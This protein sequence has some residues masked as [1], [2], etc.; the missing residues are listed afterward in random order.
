MLSRG[1]QLNGTAEST[2]E[3]GGA[4]V[5][6]GWFLESTN[7]NQVPRGCFSR[8]VIPSPRVS[9]DHPRILTSCR[10]DVV[11][12]VARTHALTHARIHARNIT[13]TITCLEDTEGVAPVGRASGA[14]RRV[15]RQFATRSSS[16]RLSSAWHCTRDDPGPRSV[17]GTRMTPL[18]VGAARL[19][20]GRISGSNGWDAMAFTRRRSLNGS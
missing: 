7:I 8:R 4:C 6:I 19:R 14:W 11:T 20:G 17:L 18:C 5:G 3:M 16:D 2:E 10:V 15:P 9:I 12:V 1:S 13:A